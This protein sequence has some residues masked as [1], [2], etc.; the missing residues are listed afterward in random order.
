MKRT[1]VSLIC[2]IIIGLFFTSCL[3]DAEETEPTSSVALLSFCIN[4]LKTQYTVTL[5]NGEDSTYTVITNTSDLRFAIDHEQGLVYNID[6]IAY[7]TDVTH[8]V[9]SMSVDGYVFYY[10]GEDKIV[11]SSG[12]TVNFASPVKFTVVSYDEK[13]SRDYLISINVSKTDPKVTYWEQI[14]DATFPSGLFVALKGVIKDSRLYVFGCDDEGN[15]YT[16]STA[17][18]DGTLWSDAVEWNGIEDGSEVDCSSIT[19]FK[20]QFYVLV[21]SILYRSID[22]V[23]WEVAA[24]EDISCLFAV[25]EGVSPT[26][27]GIADNVFVSSTD[28]LVWDATAQ[29]ATNEIKRVAFFNEALRT[30]PHIQRTIVVATLEQAADTC[31]K[32]WSK[33]STEKVWTEVLP[34][35]GNIYGCPNLENLAVISYRGRMYAFGGKSL[36]MRDVSIEAFGACYESRD[37]GVTWRVR[38]NAFSLSRDFIGRDE[39]FSAI[40]DDQDRVWIIWNKSGEVWRGTWT[41]ENA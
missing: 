39:N 14:E 40:V 30:N 21:N 22:G 19:L 23:V 15:C 20:G 37:N 5:D 41:G 12:D 33:L 1:V 9:P 27:W 18:S 13:F 16:T 11:Y 35:E 10:K 38:D 28:L 26:V 31:A 4:D 3:T 36:G 7:G 17:I 8:V 6:P 29:H 2:P 25:A 34:V 32:V 24:D